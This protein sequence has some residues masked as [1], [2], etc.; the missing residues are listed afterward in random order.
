M[1][2]FHNS[3]KI[4]CS[5]IS[6]VE[7]YATKLIFPQNIYIYSIL[8]DRNHLTIENDRKTWIS[9]DFIPWWF[10]L[11]LFFYLRNRKKLLHIKLLGNSN[12]VFSFQVTEFIPPEE[13]KTHTQ[14]WEGTFNEFSSSSRKEGT[15]K[16]YSI[17][18]SAKWNEVK[19]L[20]T[21]IKIKMALFRLSLFFYRFQVND[22]MF[23]FSLLNIRLTTSN[24]KNEAK[25]F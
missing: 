9:N 6:E 11:L 24:I 15:S 21:F 16:I 10:F 7:F 20:R 2:L 22:A 12:W 23:F 1:H 14:T 25:S 4:Q 18:R 3:F 13:K 5:W 8:C 17:H 19:L